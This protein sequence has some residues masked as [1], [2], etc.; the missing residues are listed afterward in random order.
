M[1]AGVTISACLYFEIG[2]SLSPRRRA[3]AAGFVAVIPGNAKRAVSLPLLSA[4]APSGMY[5]SYDHPRRAARRCKPAPWRGKGSG[6]YL[7][8]PFDRFSYS[9]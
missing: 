7:A 6:V 9:R 3:I 1:T 4:G 8:M 5:L 2:S